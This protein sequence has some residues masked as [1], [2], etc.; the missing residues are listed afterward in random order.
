[1]CAVSGKPWRHTT[2]G[3]SRS[4]IDS[5]VRQ[6][7]STPSALI[8][9]NGSLLTPGTVAVGH[10]V[11]GTALFPPGQ[12]G[13]SLAWISGDDDARVAESGIRVT[14]HGVRGSTP[15][16]GA[17]VLGYGGNTSCVSVRVPRH[18]PIVFDMGTGLRY[19]G[20]TL[21]SDRPFHGTCLVSH[22]HWDHIQGL[23]FF[24]PIL[25]DGATIQVVAPRQEPPRT[26][27][28]MF[29]EAIGPPLFPVHLVTL[30]GTIGF[31]EVTDDEFTI[32]EVEVV[33]RLIP[34]VGP[35]CGYRITH[36]GLSV[37]YLSD[38][39]MPSDGS[40]SATDGALELCRDADLVIHDA[41]YTPEEFANK[42]DWGHCTVDYAVWLAGEAGAERLAL[43]HHDPMHD[44]ATIDRLAASAAECGAA[45]GV[46]VFAAREGET[47]SLDG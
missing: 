27:A 16:H 37:A 3:R 15:C 7:T 35:T 38:H 32:G 25:R 21:P 45:N 22:L 23:P 24:T 30:P 6:L 28:Q 10:A 31:R 9:S 40:F 20:L 36:G 43:F 18:E 33:S 4:A 2:S 44:D 29:A 13:A 12:R 46:T 17:D 47:I 42:S 11:A 1:V 34:H 19:F 39:Q 8:R 41:Q 5:E 14:F 26:A